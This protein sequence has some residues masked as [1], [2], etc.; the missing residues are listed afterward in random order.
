MYRAIDRDGSLVD[1]MLNE[2]RAMV[3]AQA[4]FQQAVAATGQ[5]PDL[6]VRRVEPALLLLTMA[7]DHNLVV[8]R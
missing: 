6:T 3:A 5:P 1:G 8:V 7:D 4:F 2:T